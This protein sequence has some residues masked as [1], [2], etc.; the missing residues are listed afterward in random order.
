MFLLPHQNR[1]NKYNRKNINSSNIIIRL[2]KN[3]MRM[4]EKKKTTRNT[5]KIYNTNKK[6]SW[7]ESSL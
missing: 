6:N 3:N 4:K 1:V 2:R 7:L 5:K